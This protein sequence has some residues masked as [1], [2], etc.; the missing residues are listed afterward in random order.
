MDKEN[1]YNIFKKNFSNFISH[2]KSSNEENSYIDSDYEDLDTSE[3][4][5]EQFN[6]D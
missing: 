2:S 6:V 3:Y 1:I 5:D 4:E